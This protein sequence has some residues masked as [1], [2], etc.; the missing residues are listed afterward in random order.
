MAHHCIISG[1]GRAG[2][3]FLVILLTRLGVDTGYTSETAVNNNIPHAGLDYGYIKSETP[4]PYVIKGPWLCVTLEDSLKR[5]PSL[6]IDCAL[7]PMR[8]LKAAAESRVSVQ[9]KTAG[10]QTEPR[11]PGGL[12]LT[13]D[14]TEQQA[15]LQEQ[16]SNLIACLARYD[17]PL[18]LL[19]YPR[20]VKDPEYLYNKLKFLLGQTSFKEFE[21]VFSE[22]VQPDLVHQFTA[23]D[24]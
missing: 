10:A 13:A 15:V 14:P 17:I 6:V 7:V 2:T 24:V 12:W 3:T 8:D 11:L 16:L 21:H 1:T 20:L 4:L 18:L 19:W 22:L 9:E 5:D 23:V